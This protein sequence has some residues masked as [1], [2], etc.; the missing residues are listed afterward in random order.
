MV[1]TIDTGMDYFRSLAVLTVGGGNQSLNVADL[2]M[3]TTGQ[4][5]GAYLGGTRSIS[6]TEPDGNDHQLQVGEHFSVANTNDPVFGAT[7]TTTLNL[8]LVGSGTYGT[9]LTSSDVLLGVDSTG[10]QYLIF[11]DG[12]MPQLLGTVLATINLKAVGYDFD[13]HGPICFVRGVL[14]ATTK[15][16]KRVETLKIGDLVLTKDNGSKPVRWIGHRKIGAELLASK[17]ELAPIRIKVGALGPNMPEKDLVVSQQHRILVRSKIAQKMFD[18]NEV[19]VAAKLLLDI[20]GIEICDDMIEV[21]YFHLL[22]DQHEIIF[23]NGAET[24]SLYTGRQAL[25]SVSIAARVELFAIFPD[26]ENP[27]HDDPVPAR[28]LAFGHKARQL[29]ARHVK[30]SSALVGWGLK[31]VLVALTGNGWFES[32]LALGAMGL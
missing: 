24:E 10:K 16:P 22:F 2:G 4:S 29:A 23:A 31:A 19:L 25:K 26:L 3:L 20:D 30:N 14:I 11:P 13:D 32:G 7:T 9:L 6:L 28:L 15:G 1:V 18:G 12:D 27:A 17:P 5:S 8:T 21:D